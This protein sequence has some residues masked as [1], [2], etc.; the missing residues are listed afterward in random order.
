MLINIECDLFDIVTRLK[1]IDCNYYVVYNKIKD[2]FEVHYHG[3]TPAYCL[4]VPYDFLD[5]RTVDLVLK[6]KVSNSKKLFKEI[7]SHNLNL[8]KQNCQKA[9]DTA[10]Y[11]SGL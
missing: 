7:D 3:Q 10:M 6:T 4:T 8:Q 11:N 1:E 9:F 2:K 5:A